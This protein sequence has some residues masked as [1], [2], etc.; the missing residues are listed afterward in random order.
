MCELWFEAE[1]TEL[2]YDW[3]MEWTNQ[4]PALNSFS[5]ILSCWKD[6]IFEQ[7]WLK[8]NSKVTSGAEP[9]TW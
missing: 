2:I 1:N 3:K 6:S 9:P 8:P 7:S 4:H 5:P